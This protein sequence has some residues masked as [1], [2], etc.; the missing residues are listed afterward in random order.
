MTPASV[1]VVVAVTMTG[2]TGDDDSEDA[3]SKFI[4]GVREVARR[5]IKGS[6]VRLV[7]Y[8]PGW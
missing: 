5:S 6:P 8:V 4:A 1:V 7:Q 2:Y 3:Y